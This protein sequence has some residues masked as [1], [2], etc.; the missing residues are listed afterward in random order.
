MP[1]WEFWLFHIDHLSR[2]LFYVKNCP[3]CELGCGEKALKNAFNEPEKRN[4][5]AYEKAQKSGHLTVPLGLER[6]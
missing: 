4:I 6:H 3:V 5:L 1:R 2:K